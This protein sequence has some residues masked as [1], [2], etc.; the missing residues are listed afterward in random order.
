MSLTAGFATEHQLQSDT[1]ERNMPLL[2]TAHSVTHHQAFRQRGIA[3]HAM[4]MEAYLAISGSRITDQT[5]LIP[6]SA[7]RAT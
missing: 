1:M 6:I 7:I 4:L 5:M 3:R 2:V